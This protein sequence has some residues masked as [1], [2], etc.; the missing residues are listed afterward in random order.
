MST[1]IGDERLQWLERRRSGIGGSDAAAILGLSRWKSRLELFCEK[2]GLD[3]PEYDIP[4]WI[5]WGNLLEP[6]IAGRYAE[7]TGFALED[8]GRYTIQRHGTHYY[9]ICTVDRFILQP[10]D[11]PTRGVLEIKNV[12]GFKGDEWAEE[13]PTEY[14]IQAQHQMIVTGTTWGAFGVLFG[15]QRF[16]YF[17]FVKNERFCAYYIQQAAEFW[18]RVEENNPPDADGS[19]SSREAL[20]RLFP[21]ETGETRILDKQL[22]ATAWRFEGTKKAIKRLQAKESEFKNALLQAI[23]D[24]TFGLLPDG[25]RYSLK[26]INKPGHTVEATSFRQLR[27]VKGKE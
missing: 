25:S 1:Q 14:Q 13:P 12:A 23:G 22:T 24:A 2:I 10:T 16:E 9:L 15:G 7:V 21:K 18:Q 6:V 17:P 20:R 11:M 26:T 8:P 3:E 4:E 27:K 5:T 19:E